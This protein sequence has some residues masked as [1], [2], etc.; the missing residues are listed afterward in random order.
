MAL[1]DAPECIPFCAVRPVVATRNSWSASGNGSGRFA[2]FCE[3]LC[4]APSSRYATPNGS[5]PATATLTPPSEAAAVRAARVHRRA[6]EDQ[7]AGDV[8]TL[9]WKLHDALAL[10]NLADAGALH[11]DERRFRLHRDRLL[12]VSERQ[13]DVDR[14]GRGD[15]E[16]DPRL[17][18]R[19]EPLQRD[20][21]P[22]RARRRD[23]IRGTAVARR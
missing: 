6:R 21:E 18:V 3:S 12:D 4:I 22:I 20:L 8:T 2:L 16:H 19:A 7:Q 15:L 23:W 11:V 10:D 13:R 9:E 1:T 17:R 5:P 14:W